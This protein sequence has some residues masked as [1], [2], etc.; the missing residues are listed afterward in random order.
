MRPN[1]SKDFF[2][3]AILYFFIKLKYLLVQKYSADLDTMTSLQLM[4]MHKHIYR[5]YQ[6]SE[7]FYVPK[8]LQYSC[9]RGD[10]II[11]G[12]KSV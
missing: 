12:G 6:V 4:Y 1:V 5:M 11:G 10:I 7:I 3:F 8:Q 2:A 9:P